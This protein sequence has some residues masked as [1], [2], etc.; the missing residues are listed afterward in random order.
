[1][2]RSTV[3]A[4]VLLAAG[5]SAALLSLVQARLILRDRPAHVFAMPELATLADRLGIT[6][7]RVVEGAPLIE[8]AVLVVAIPGYAALPWSVLAAVAVARLWRWYV[9]P[10]LLDEEAAPAR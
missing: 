10:G 8:L 7:P 6:L 5:G 9:G 2:H 1:T 3:A 4:V